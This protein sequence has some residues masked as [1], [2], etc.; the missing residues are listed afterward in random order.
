MFIFADNHTKNI[1]IKCVSVLSPTLTGWIPIKL[2]VVQV[3]FAAF[4]RSFSN[5]D[6]PRFKVNVQY[7]PRVSTP[8]LNNFSEITRVKS[9]AEAIQVGGTA[10]KFSN[11]SKFFS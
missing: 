7:A 9:V 10:F 5:Q 2:K 6:R 1:F 8:Q 4:P 11:E 3:E